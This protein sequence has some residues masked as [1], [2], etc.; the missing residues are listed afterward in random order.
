MHPGSPGR[1]ADRLGVIA[2]ILATFDVG[3]DVLGRDQAHLVTERDQLA[4]PMVSTAAG[5]HCNLCGKKPR[6]EWDHL[7]AAEIYPQHRPLLLIDT[8]QSEDGLGRVDADAFILDH[9]RLRTWLFTAPILA[10]DAVGPGGARH[11]Q[12]DHDRRAPMSPSTVALAAPA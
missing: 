2:V 6:E 7:C 8:M 12:D 3:L 5:F 11:A 10:H 1:L 4:S 9:G